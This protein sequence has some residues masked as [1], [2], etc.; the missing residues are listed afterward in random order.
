MVVVVLKARN[1]PDKHSFYKQ[2]VF[3]QV[4]LQGTTKKTKVDIKGGQHPVW[5]EELRFP[6]FDQGKKGMMMEVSCWSKEPRSDD[7]VGKG[8]LDISE[9]LRTGEFDDWIPLGVNNVQRGDLYLEMTFYAAGPPP[10]LSRR[11]SKMLPAD[12]LARLPQT[13]PPSKTPSSPPTAASHRPALTTETTHLRPPSVTSQRLSP[14]VK[15][16]ELPPLPE[17][18]ASDPSSPEFVPAILRPGGGKAPSPNHRSRASTGTNGHTGSFSPPGAYPHSSPSHSSSVPPPDALRPGA[19]LSPVSH[20]S[21]PSRTSSYIPEAQIPTLPA[22]VLGS[23]PTSTPTP[24]PPRITS[25]IQ[26]PVHEHRPIYVPSPS[27]TPHY[28]IHTSPS[29]RATYD[30]RPQ[31]PPSPQPPHQRTYSTPQ[32]YPAYD[33]RAHTLPPPAPSPYPPAP[34]VPS[35]QSPPHDQRPIPALPPQ[36]GPVPGY[37]PPQA[38]W[39]APPPASYPHLQP[40]TFTAGVGGFAFPAPSVSPHPPPPP[41]NGYYPPYGPAPR[42]YP[43]NYPPPPRDPDLEPPVPLNN[44]RYQ[45]PL[46]LPDE[47]EGTGTPT[48]AQPQGHIS[49]APKHGGHH[50]QQKS[51]SG[52]PEKEKYQSAE[53]RDR[54]IAAAI[55]RE[56]EERR[57]LAREQEERDLE[58]ARK[59]DLELNLTEDDTAS[60]P[61]YEGAVPNGDANRNGDDMPGAWYRHRPDA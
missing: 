58:L 43:Y 3:A 15:E 8:E 16:A 12:R 57:R 47:P 7:L 55:E 19:G 52:G 17:E 40:S 50:R 49:P 34:Y 24:Q 23:V 4:T 1:L 53:E 54:I 21:P 2:D 11:P 60:P 31:P 38:Q 9:T 35:S 28:S 20:T 33:A 36:P 45:K 22:S 59:L 39:Q 61:S 5:D 26:E 32:E 56:E 37:A 10:A 27:P 41:A 13:S 6:I 46:P 51:V 25:P 48:P 29:T 30:S 18:P 44:P 42:P 14:R